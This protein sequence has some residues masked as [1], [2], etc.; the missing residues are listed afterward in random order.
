MS[1]SQSRR[2]QIRSRLLELA[3]ERTRLEA[4]LS[5]FDYPVLDL[6]AEITTH[7][8]LQFLPCDSQPSSSS[9][10]LLLT[11]ICRQWRQIALATA[12]LWQSIAF[13]RVYWNHGCENLLYMWLHHSAGLPLFLSFGCRSDV[14]T[15][16]LIDASLIHCHQW[17]KITLSGRVTL[18]VPNLYFP[19]LRKVTLGT[20]LRGISGTIRIQNAPLLCD[21]TTLVPDTHYNVQLP[22]AQLTSLAVQT[23][24]SSA[25][26]LPML[27]QCSDHLLHLSHTG[28]AQ[29][30]TAASAAIS[31]PHITLESLESL[32][33]RG[34]GIMPHL[35]LPGLRHLILT[36]KFWT[37]LETSQVSR[38]LS[39][40]LAHLERLSIKFEENGQ[41]NLTEI[42]L[43]FQ[44]V[45]TVTDFAITLPT[46]VELSRVVGCFSSADTL[47]AMENLTIDA[48]RVWDKNGYDSLLRFLRARRS[49]TSRRPATLK[50]FELSLWPLSG[51]IA[52]V[53]MAQ[54]HDLARDGLSTRIWLGSS[55]LL[56]GGQI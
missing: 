22:L 1:E 28:D 2:A 29:Q 34:S 37:S 13:G 44:S 46:D 19:L 25:D 15:Q 56:D 7:I 8:F 4:E 48:V 17:Q 32:A 6:P 47:P 36:V 21:A 33:V 40:S 50:S 9:A 30:M 24:G 55:V 23:S 53:A 16:R 18:D 42:Q 27:R 49:Q 45:P 31:Q 11:K 14:Q 39:R 54:L 10:P 51:P 52:E 3:A 35:T 20:H 26:C 41:P 38:L 43:L 12:P 5:S